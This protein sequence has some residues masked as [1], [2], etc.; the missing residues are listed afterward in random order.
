MNMQS[1]SNYDYKVGGIVPLD[2]LTYIKRKADDE[3]YNL[4]KAGEFCYVFNSRQMGKSSLLI[5]T[6]SRLEAEGFACVNI[7]I[8]GDIGTD[9]ENPKQW[10]DTFIEI[11][12]DRLNLELPDWWD[13][14][15]SL[16]SL[17]CLTKFFEKILFISINKNIVIFIDEI[18]SL[19]DLRF[20]ID[21]FFAFIRFCYNK[22]ASNAN[23]KRITFA[24]FGVATPSDMIR[25][26]RRTPFNIGRAVELTGITFEEAKDKLTQGF[27]DKV[28]NPKKVLVEI[29]N[30]TGGQPFLTQKLCDIVSKKAHIGNPDIEHLARKY[31]IEN[32]ISQDKPQHFETIQGRILKDSK[33]AIL[34]LKLYRIILLDQEIEADKTKEQLELRLSGLVVEKEEK[35][36]VCNRIYE[37]IFNLRWLEENLN[38]L[39][40]RTA[41]KLIRFLLRWMPSGIA[42]F[43]TIHF[44]L[45]QA[46]IQTFI[47]FVLTIVCFLWAEFSRGLIEKLEE[48]AVKRGRN[49]ADLVLRNL[50][51]LLLTWYWGTFQSRYYQSLIYTYRDYRTE[52]L[53]TK[54]PFTLDLEKVFVPLR[55]ATESFEHTSPVTI[56]SLE[57]TESSVIWDFLAASRTNPTYRSLAIIGAPGSGKTTLLKYL[58]LIYAKNAQR[59]QHP[60]A[61]K[62]IPILLY[63]REVWETIANEQPSLAALVERQQS[64]RKLNPPPHWFKNQLRQ[65][66]CLVMLDGLDE[67]VDEKQRQKVSRWIEQQIQNY[68]N[69]RFILTSRPSGYRSTPVE[70]VGV[71]LEVH[72]FNLMQVQPF[73]QNWYLQQ[74]IMRHLGKDDPAVRHNAQ[75]QAQDLIRR[76]ENSPPLAAMAVNPLLLTMIATVHCYRGALPGRRVELYGEICDVL[77]GGRP[78]AKGISDPLTL[79]QKKTVLQVLA[80]ELMKRRTREFTPIL[81]STLIQNQ[82]AQVVST[83]LT[84]EV[85]LEKIQHESGLLVERENGVYEFAHLSFQEYLAAVEVK[86]S[87]QEHILLEHIGDAWWYDTIRLYAAR[88][89]AT[90]LIRAALD[91]PTVASLKLAYDCLEE[92]LRVEP[93]V[94]RQLQDRL[95][96]ALESPSREMSSLAA[97]IKLSERLSQLFQIDKNL[98]RVILLGDRAVGKT[99]LLVSLANSQGKYVKVVDPNYAGLINKLLYDESLADTISTDDVHNLPLEI[100]VSLPFEDMTF[101]TEFID[102][103]GEIWSMDWSMNNP[104]MQY[105][106]NMLN[107]ATSIILVIPPYREIIKSETIA[108]KFSTQSE[109]VMR[110]EQWVNLFSRE[111]FPQLRHLIVCLNKAD[112]F[113]EIEQEAVELRYEPTGSR[114]NWFERHKYVLERYFRPI[115]TQIKQLNQNLSDLSV[116]CFITSTYNRDLLELPWIF[117]SSYLL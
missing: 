10:Y 67:I 53:K 48:V 87:S 52:G 100:N 71:V 111:S 26:K 84:P 90:K 41:Q 116:S 68:P 5:R 75:R 13:S 78:E 56:Q 113:C 108:S 17:R 89:N 21:D 63:L 43:V 57:R 11:I 101:A 74:E 83:P 86:E 107:S 14:C 55:V 20:S 93:E 32:W 37:E 104:D 54:G 92:A 31:M 62:L 96:A 30:W 77:L 19:L 29:L 73:I 49:S 3:L 24:L 112:L 15:K 69:T 115:K 47:S 27:A 97:E 25:D 44:L 110:F 1:N 105:F 7:D 95:E 4:L 8:S 35:L 91:N 65:R 64:I 18:D 76:I 81:A 117:L 28:E 82:L 40:P 60:K 12:V 2:N 45:T 103:P 50:E 88:S 51:S 70:R 59:R 9:L 98:K 42:I 34:L 39:R 114:M 99:S 80:L 36:T 85:F 6:M 33:K 66:R 58:T 38:T 46:W 16:P 72:P 109:W 94:L 106:F 22:R 102:T 61:P 79:S 23:Y